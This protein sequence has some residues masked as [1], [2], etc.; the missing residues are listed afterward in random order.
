MIV[1]DA[2]SAVH[3]L[4]DT[5]PFGAVVSAHLREQG[6]EAAAPHLLDAEVGQVLRRFVLRGDMGPTRARRALGH[7]SLL[8]ISR[9]PH[10]PFLERAFSTHRDLTVYDGLYVALAEA[11]GVPLLTSDRKLAAAARR[12]VRVVEIGR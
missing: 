11:L 5:P 1:L 3:L 2:S 12:R 9:Y 10:H 7:L 8:P 4:L 6:G